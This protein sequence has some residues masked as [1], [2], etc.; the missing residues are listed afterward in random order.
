MLEIEAEAEQCD[1]DCGTKDI[2]DTNI[3][4][5]KVPAGY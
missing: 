1:A 3:H 2:A 4:D 5:F